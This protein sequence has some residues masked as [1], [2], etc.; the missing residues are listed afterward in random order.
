MK[1]HFI[2]RVYLITVLAFFSGELI[3]QK[4]GF[5]KIR[6]EKEKVAPGLIWKS[7]HTI[8]NNSVPQN[9]NILNVNLKKRKICLLYDPEKNVPLSK[10]AASVNAIA[11]V[12]GGFFNI[13]NGGSVTYIRTGG[14]IA[15][16]DTAKKW[17]RNANMTGSVLI[18]NGSELF[19]DR[20][21]S[22]QWLDIHPEYDDILITGPLLVEKSD[23]VILPATSL[24]INKHPRTAIGT[25]NNRKVLLVTLD[26][27]TNEAAGMTLDELAALMISLRCR[28]AVNLDGGGS[29]TMWINGKPF[30][31]VVNMPCDNKQYD[32]YGERAVSDIL[33]IK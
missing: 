15:D 14:K 10:Q 26:G 18:K 33:V 13:K 32:H 17:S 9:I 21:M 29:T 11:A 4:G 24:V 23:I 3:A 31:G 2:L 30:N 27:R 1:R 6:W 7:S 25:K 28:D 8:L 5:S 16:S 22:N 20:S 12:N 19:I